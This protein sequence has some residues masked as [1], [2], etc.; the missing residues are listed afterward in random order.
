MGDAGL[1]PAMAG[2]G[3][4]LHEEATLDLLAD[5]LGIPQQNTVTR[6]PDS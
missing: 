5:D 1:A 4:A 3:V 6:H 2:L